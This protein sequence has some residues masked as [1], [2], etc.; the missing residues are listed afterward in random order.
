MEAP[1]VTM[2][3]LL[4]M[5][6]GVNKEV[7]GGARIAR[8]CFTLVTRAREF[9]LLAQGNRSVGDFVI[10]AGDCF[11]PATRRR[12][13]FVLRTIKLMTQARADSMPLSLA[14][15]RRGNK[16]TGDGVISARECFTPAT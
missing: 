2:L 12:R 1:V 9:V 14:M 3:L 6:L 5:M 8:E 15:M 16:V 11:T 13:E 7:G 10:S 4:A